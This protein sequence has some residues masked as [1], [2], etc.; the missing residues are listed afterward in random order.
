MEAVLDV[1][2][3][4]VKIKS[5]YPNVTMHLLYIKKVEMMIG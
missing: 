5:F 3:R 4:G 2:V 1:H